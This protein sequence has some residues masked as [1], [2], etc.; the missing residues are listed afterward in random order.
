MDRARRRATILWLFLNRFDWVALTASREAAD[1]LA[2]MPAT[3]QIHYQ[4]GWLFAARS[5]VTIPKLRLVPGPVATLNR[6]AAGDVWWTLRMTGFGSYLERS[7]MTWLVRFV[8]RAVT[9]ARFAH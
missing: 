9:Q 7:P 3:N 5:V 4:F 8:S 6:R 2:R 1:V